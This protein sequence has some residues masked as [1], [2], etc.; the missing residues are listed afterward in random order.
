MYNLL[1]FQFARTADDVVLMVNECGD[2]YFID[3][4]QFDLFVRHD[5]DE[6]TDEFLDLKSKLFA[7]GPEGLEL[8]LQKSAA[9]HRT[10]KSFL[11]EFTNL[12]MMVITLRCNQRCDYCQVSCAGEDATL[13]D[14]SEDTARRVV[15]M[16]FRSPSS[17]PK[18]EFQGGE[19]L[20]NWPAIKAAVERATELS[21]REGKAASFVICT[22]LTAITRDQLL[23]CRDHGVSIS[24]SL[25]GPEAIHDACRKSPGGEGTHSRFL[26]KLDLAREVL[27]ESGVDALMTTTSFSVGRLGEVIEEYLRLG[28]GGIFIRSL[29]PY[30]FAAQQAA[31]LG[32]SMGDFVEKYL[33]ALEKLVDL[34]I[35]G[36]YFPD[37][38]AALLFT[39]MLTPFATGFVDLQSPSGCG[40]S[41]AIYDFDGAVY[42][43]DE[44]RMLAR[45]GDGYFRLGSVLHDSFGDIFA[46]PK[47]RAMTARACVET[48]PG[49]AW[50]AYQAYCGTDPVRNYLETGDE[51]RPMEGSPFCVKHKGIFDGLFAMLRRGDPKVRDVIWSWVSRDPSLV[52]RV[53]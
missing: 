44:A 48:T 27:G 1:P 30:G 29:N 13:Y 17:R 45:M 46:G 3:K 50:C 12:H 28:M 35:R 53:A 22:N 14:M 11:R 20:L 31:A 33:G 15:D 51:V 9:R 7:C 21:A 10:R 40:I 24:T 26:E 43:S 5:L 38:F 37:F 52:E 23:F 42:P 34:N 39:R 2:Y 32:Y 36:R 4:K 8:A 47:M 6:S 18:I 49:C 16:V 25:D 19:P 41:G